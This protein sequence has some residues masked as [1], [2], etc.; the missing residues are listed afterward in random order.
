MTGLMA[1]S[2][3]NGVPISITSLVPDLDHYKGSFGG[4]VFALWKDSA[5]TKTNVSTV[6]TKAFSTA[7]GC[8]VDP[9]DIFAYT[10]GVLA[11][12]AFTAAHRDDLIRPG[13]RVPMTADKK[14][15]DRAVAL[16]RDV[17]WLHTF[18][19]RMN[20]GK[21]AGEPRLPRDR[22]PTIPAA[23]P[24]RTDP[25]NFP[26][27]LAYDAEGQVMSIGSGR[28]ENV[29]P[30]VWEYEVSGKNVLRQ[31]FSYRKKDRTR[32]VIGDKRPPSDLNKIQSD[33]WLPEYTSELINVLN[34]LAMLVELE[35]A[36]AALLAKIEDGPLI[37][38]KHKKATN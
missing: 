10:A 37:P 26:D 1:H 25:D 35:P 38:T 3:T 21:P 29:P 11:H 13:L 28:I 31:W 5:A 27:T 24:I 14:L 8:E 17:I 32:P 9:V 23:H 19:E 7:F 4:R 18:G 15:F 34:V 12:P 16:G 2:P 30:E 20:D 36:Q 22:Q 6:A 33:R